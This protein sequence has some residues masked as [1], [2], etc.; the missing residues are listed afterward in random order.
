MGAIRFLTAI[1]QRMLYV[2]LILSESAH[3]E[4]LENNA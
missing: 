1:E 2:K 4:I 3:Q